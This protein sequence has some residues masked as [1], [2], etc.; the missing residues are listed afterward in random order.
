MK[1]PHAVACPDQVDLHGAAMHTLNPHPSRILSRLWLGF[2]MGALLVGAVGAKPGGSSE[3][4]AVDATGLVVEASEVA[5]W[6]ELISAPGPVTLPGFP[7]SDS[8]TVDLELTRFAVTSPR[9]RFVVGHEQRP[10]DFD[11]SSVVLLR[12]RVHGHPRVPSVPG[13]VR[14]RQ[15]GLRRPRSIRGAL[16]SLERS[17]GGFGPHPSA[18]GSGASAPRAVARC[19]C[20]CAGSS[21]LTRHPRTTPRGAFSAPPAS[22][23]SSSPS[24]RTTRCFSSSGIWRPPERTSFRSTVSCL[25]SSSAM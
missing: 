22:S 2:C 17:S 11:P 25:T 4:T 24:R 23:T 15:P 18:F 8:Q 5:A 10:L 6:R 3:S 9:T 7:L 1:V 12:G 14:L 21:S 19:P 20:L 16:R 13:A